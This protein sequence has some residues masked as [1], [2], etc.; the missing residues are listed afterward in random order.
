ME[1]RTTQ[2]NVHIK[3]YV[4]QIVL[5]SAVC[6]V[7]SQQILPQIGTGKWRKICTRNDCFLRKSNADVLNGKQ[8]LSSPFVSTYDFTEYFDQINLIFYGRLKILPTRSQS[9]YAYWLT[10]VTVEHL[11]VMFSAREL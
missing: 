2:N 10:V 1:D 9:E 3:E 4:E 5:T 11:S 7:C 6:H 8:T